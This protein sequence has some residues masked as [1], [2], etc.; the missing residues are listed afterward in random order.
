MSLAV[1]VAA[2]AIAA[3]RLSAEHVDRAPVPALVFLSPDAPLLGCNFKPRT[4]L[5]VHAWSLRREA[6]HAR[7]YFGPMLAAKAW[8]VAKQEK[9]AGAYGRRPC[10]VVA[11][12]G[13]RLPV[14]HDRGT[15]HLLELASQ[16]GS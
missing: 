16:S 12:P 5:Y 3:A 4:E 2:S 6:T 8:V 14:V 1:A 10:R 7:T 15:V 11:A 13:A 9:L